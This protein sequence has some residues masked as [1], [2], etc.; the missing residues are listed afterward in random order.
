MGKPSLGASQ[1][2]MCG[3]VESAIGEHSEDSISLDFQNLRGSRILAQ[4]REEE[5]RLA[6]VLMK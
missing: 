2:W 5:A 1:A 6:R 3:G 4:I